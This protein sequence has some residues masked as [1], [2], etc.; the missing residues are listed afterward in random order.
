MDTNL[1][2]TEQLLPNEDKF[3]NDF[4]KRFDLRH[5]DTPLELNN[6]VAKNYRFP[7]FYADTS[8]AI[9]IFHCD[10]QAAKAMM[11]DPSM[12]PVKM[13]KGRSLVIFSCYEYRH[14]MNVAP[15]NEIA[16]TI[17]VIT[18]GGMNIPVLSM[19]LGDKSKKFG[20]YVFNMPVTSLEN[21]IRGRK[22]WGLPKDTEQV[23]IE[24]DGQFSTIKTSVNSEEPYFELKVP[25][26]GSSQNFDV[27]SNLFSMLDNNRLTST[28]Q[29][30]GQF[31]INKNIAS[32]LKKTTLNSTDTIKIGQGPK[33]EQ[34]R[35]LK[36][37]GQAFQFRYSPSINA[38]F[39]LAHEKVE[40]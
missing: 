22:L 7:T 6:S 1:K 2:I 33:A 23:D 29:F 4:F 20:Y 36:I 11:P 9:A 15:Y 17:P 21:R 30:K 5:R 19:L 32:L 16:M 34:L 38:C 26:N 12:E 14:V 25:M 8:C 27:K 40:K 3:N 18:D 35:A 10:Y 13:T 31:S 28:T 24:Q 37:E 39:D